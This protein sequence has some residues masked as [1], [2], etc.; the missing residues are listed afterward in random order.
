MLALLASLSWLI[1]WYVVWVLP[2]AALGAS[3]RLRQ[4]TIVMTCFL[5]VTFM[6]ATGMAMSALHL[7]LLD[8]PAGRASQTL[9][10][11]LSG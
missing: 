11:S 4:W 9:Q 10:N 3:P 2:L 5:V 6:P 1:P 8:T 7:N